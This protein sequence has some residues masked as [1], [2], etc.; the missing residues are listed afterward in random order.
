[1]RMN[2]VPTSPRRGSLRRDHTDSVSFSL[3]ARPFALINIPHRSRDTCQTTVIFIFTGRW[4]TSWLIE[5]LIGYRTGVHAF[6]S[7]SARFRVYG[8]WR[9]PTWNNKFDDFGE[10]KQCTWDHW[11]PQSIVTTDAQFF[12]SKWMNRLL[13]SLQIISTQRWPES[14]QVTMDCQKWV[15]AKGRKCIQ[16]Q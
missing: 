7:Q 8:R 3:T 10:F 6:D 16:G 5:V 11:T 2:N 12:S 15:G 14:L 4:G 13:E 1:M 9:S